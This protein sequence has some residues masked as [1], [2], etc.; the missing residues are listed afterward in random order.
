MG[1]GRTLLSWDVTARRGL[2]AGMHHPFRREGLRIRTESPTGLCGF[3]SNVSSDRRLPP[4]SSSPQTRWSRAG[5]VKG[6]GLPAEAESLKGQVGAPTQAL[7][8]KLDSVWNE[9]LV[10]TSSARRTGEQ[11]ACLLFTRCKRLDFLTSAPCYSHG[12]AR[13]GGGGGNTALRPLVALPL[14]TDCK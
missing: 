12:Q 6:G 9:V 2:Q 5:E 11:L 3:S 14:P 4:L 7:L 8:A 1:W 13:G 10:K